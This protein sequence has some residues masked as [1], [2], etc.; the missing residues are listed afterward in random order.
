MRCQGG[1]FH[2]HTKKKKLDT[3][4]PHANSLGRGETREQKATLHDSKQRCG[5]T[6]HPLAAL[7]SWGGTAGPLLGRWGAIGTRQSLDMP[8]CIWAET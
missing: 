3:F 2:T 5:I 6:G 1:I 8:D 7:G 4:L